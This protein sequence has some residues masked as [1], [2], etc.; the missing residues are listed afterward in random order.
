M[1]EM[2]KAIKERVTSDS[3][4][5][6]FSTVFLVLIVVIAY[7]K[8]S[9][10]RNLQVVQVDLIQIN[11]D[12]MGKATKLVLEVNSQATSQEKII[13]AQNVMKVVGASIESLL[14]EY[15]KKRH[16][17]II[18]KQMI[19]SDAGYPLLDITNEIEAKIDSKL[20]QQN[21]FNAA[22]Q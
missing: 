12:Y 5:K 2:I 1:N 9:N 11:N 14:D 19:A 18:Q 22:K 4:I 7:T 10:N 6:L 3:L 8:L 16:V 21:L 13:K 20:N 17:V 15:S